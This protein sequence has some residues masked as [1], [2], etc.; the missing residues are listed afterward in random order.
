M[1]LALLL[2]MG[3]L[4]FLLPSAEPALPTV[5]ARTA[6]KEA[7]VEHPT[8]GHAGVL[9]PVVYGANATRAVDLV[10]KGYLITCLC[11]GQLGLVLLL[12]YRRYETL[13]LS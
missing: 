6:D 10:G 1:A 3:C 13:M 4:L 7:A 2:T 8:E 9:E 11:M 12:L 5:S